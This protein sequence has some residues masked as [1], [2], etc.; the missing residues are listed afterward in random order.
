[1]NL[2]WIIINT[3][4]VGLRL[5]IKLEISLSWSY[6]CLTCTL[7]KKWK[8]DAY[9][10]NTSRRSQVGVNNR[11]FLIFQSN[12]RSTKKALRSQNIEE[13][14]KQSIIGADSEFDQNIM[15][16][17]RKFIDGKE[18]SAAKKQRRN[19]TSGKI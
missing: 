2:W 10:N 7:F 19:S 17:I 13:V 1:M 6:L 15:G 11:F 12:A 18:T 9:S 8:T 14:V 3:S 5:A 16:N 4:K